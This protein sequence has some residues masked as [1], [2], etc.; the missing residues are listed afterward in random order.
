MK[1]RAGYAFVGLGLLAA[2]SIVVFRRPEAKAPVSAAVRPELPA[3]DGHGQ[4]RQLAH[5]RAEVTS[6]K[7]QLVAIR[8]GLD[9]RVVQAKHPEP[10]VED[11]SS[12]SAAAPTPE[13]SRAQ[14]ALEWREHMERVAAA[15]VE[16]PVDRS[17]SKEK[18]EFLESR[19]RNDPVLNAAASGLECRSSTCRVE[20]TGDPIDVNKQLPMFVHS[21]GE[22]LP[23]AEAERIDQPDGQVTMV[24]YVKEHQTEPDEF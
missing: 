9:D 8:T 2:T 4:D 16:E 11:P 7:G 12:D 1:A 22:T 14:S 23:R 3:S 5:L 24:V 15:F 19:L 6:L 10:I 20:L 13:E 17:W 18:H 21:L